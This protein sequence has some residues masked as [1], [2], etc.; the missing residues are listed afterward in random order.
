[1]KSKLQKGEC[2]VGTWQTIPS[3]IVTDIICSAGLD[4]VIVDAEH[5][6]ISFE[7]A[8]EMA[9]ACESREVSPI[10]RVGNINEDDILKALDI[11][12]HGIQIPNIKNVDEALKQVRRALLDAD[13]SLSVVKEFINEVRVKAV[14]TEVV[15]GID[16]GQKFI[17]V[18]HEELVNVMGGEN[19]PLANSDEQPTVILMAGL[20]GAGKTTATAKLGL[21]LKEKN[22]K[23]LLVAADTYRPA[24]IDQ[25]ITLG[26]QIDV[27]VFN[28]SSN[29][30]PEEIAKKGLEKAKKEGS[31]AIKENR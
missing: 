25:L 10:M 2:T 6:P 16:P 9:I 28:L 29:L 7:T 14:G 17:Q 3:P 27:E 11:G 12:M 23:P 4:F 30:K 19:D 13:V 24:A 21:L 20:Q 5:G 22:K 1:M 15:R 18:V 8:Q 26:N 31:K